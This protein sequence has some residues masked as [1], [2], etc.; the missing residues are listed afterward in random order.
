MV[1]VT[2]STKTEL[3]A[4]FET[5]R[6]CV[7]THQWLKLQLPI[8]HTALVSYLQENQLYNNQE[9]KFPAI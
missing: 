6:K 3:I 4:Y 9:A 5:S 8:F 2:C 7:G 1:Y